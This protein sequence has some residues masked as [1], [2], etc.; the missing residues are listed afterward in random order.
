MKNVCSILII[1]LLFFGFNYNNKSQDALS[2]ENKKVIKSI[3]SK[4]FKV[5]K[6]RKRL[7]TDEIE[8]DYDNYIKEFDKNGKIIKEVN[9]FVDG[10]ETEI[11]YLYDDKDSL[12]EKIVYDINDD[13]REIKYA[14]KYEY[15]NNKL[16]NVYGLNDE[17]EVI[18][19]SEYIYNENGFTV[20]EFYEGKKEE[21]ENNILKKYNNNYQEI[22]FEKNWD[23]GKYREKRLYF[24]NENNKLDSINNYYEDN[25]LFKHKYTFQDSVSIVQLI[26]YQVESEGKLVWTREYNKNDEVISFI[27]NVNKKTNDALQ[28]YDYKYDEYGNWIE[29]KLSHNI[30][31]YKITKREIEYYD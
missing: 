16:K 24:Y 9:Y 4:A 19:V 28:Y 2:N 23:D 30:V 22:S 13:E 6:I 3:K 8:Y 31:L 27:Q 7:K 10:E 29:K 21:K 15:E 18:R 20:L 12:I 5:R 11:E 25:L 26:N 17:K 14:L 1:V